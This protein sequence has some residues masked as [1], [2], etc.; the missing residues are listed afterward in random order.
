M[1]SVDGSVPAGWSADPEGFAQELR[2]RLRELSQG[3]ERVD[4]N[5]ETR[6]RIERWLSGRTQLGRGWI[7]ERS[8]PIRVDDDSLLRRR[9][10]AV[11]ELHLLPEHL[12][13]LLGD[14]RL[15]MPTWIEPAMRRIANVEAFTLGELADVLPD[16]ESRAVLGRRLIREGLLA[17]RDR[18][19]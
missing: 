9:P 3:L 1:R 4:A 14:R 6:A 18:G 11:C 15:E 5:E 10:G 7:A 12:I 13:V 17:G 16:R 19:E 8:E 2:D